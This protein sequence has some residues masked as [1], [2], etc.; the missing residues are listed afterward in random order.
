M[1][2]PIMNQLDNLRHNVVPETHTERTLEHLDPAPL[3]F[4]D[5]IWQQLIFQG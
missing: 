1:T 2:L 3:G 5:R 4:K